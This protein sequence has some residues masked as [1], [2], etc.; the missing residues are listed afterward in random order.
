MAETSGSNP[1]QSVT[2]PRLPPTPQRSTGQLSGVQIM[3]AVIL[4]VGLLLAINFSSR[5][6]ESQTLFNA[7]DR[8][9]VEKQTLEAEYTLLL[10]ESA[11]VQSDAYV[12]QWARDRGK[13]IRSGEVL[14]VP[15]PANMAATPTPI[16]EAASLQ[17]DDGIPEPEPW[18][19]WWSLFF[20]SSP[21]QFSN[22]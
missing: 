4:A 16:T 8:V 1:R 19:L 7:Y 2:R 3:F 20:D 22:P 14:I 15:V 18:Q 21:P 6:A 11:Y 10:T 9:I 17:F 12:E 13:M 5:I